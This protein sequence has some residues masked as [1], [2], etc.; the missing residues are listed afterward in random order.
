MNLKDFS[1]PE[2]EGAPF[3]GQLTDAAGDT[4]YELAI[5]GSSSQIEKTFGESELEYWIE[6][7]ATGEEWAPRFEK[8]WAS[9]TG[10]ALSSGEPETVEAL[11]RTLPSAAKAK[12]SVVVSVRRT[13]GKGTGWGFFWPALTLP[14]G[15]SAFFVLPPICNCA[16]FVVPRFGN[17]NLFLTANGPATPIIKAS[18]NG[19]GMIDAVAVLGP[20][21]CFPWTE[22]MPWFRVFAAT[23]CVS[24]FGMSGFGVFP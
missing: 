2:T 6:P 16:G 5:S 22:F 3:L 21:I 13:K 7:K 9:K 10:D 11:G 4:H 19:P 17:P 24:D 12:T 20:P 8:L 18:M 23:N 1:R 14:A 15:F